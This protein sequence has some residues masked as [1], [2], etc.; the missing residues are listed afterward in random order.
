MKVEINFDTKEIILK[1][2][3]TFSDLNKLKK[4]LGDDFGQYKL[5]CEVQSAPPLF[6]PQIWYDPYAPINHWQITC[7]NDYT[8]T[9]IAAETVTSPGTS[10]T[11]IID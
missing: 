2:Q 5:V 3:V 8:G 4:M 6:W 10:Y 7:G 9:T 1:S 11:T